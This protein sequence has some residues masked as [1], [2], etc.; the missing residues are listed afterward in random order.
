M[1][2]PNQNEG[3]TDKGIR[4]NWWITTKLPWV[5]WGLRF[6]FGIFFCLCSSFFHVHFNLFFLANTCH[7]DIK[8]LKWNQNQI[9]K[10][11]KSPHY[12]SCRGA[13]WGGQD[14]VLVTVLYRNSI[15]GTNIYKDCLVFSIRFIWGLTEPHSLT[16]YT[17]VIMYYI[18]LRI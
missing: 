17:Q 9:I 15:N 1:K 4:T 7:V 13:S 8:M 5:A 3:Q 16:V 10:Q 14:G 12:P 2:K 18:I 11:R 6:C